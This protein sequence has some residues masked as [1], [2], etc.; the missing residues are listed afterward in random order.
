MT[1]AAQKSTKGHP[2]V[3]A[4]RADRIPLAISFAFI[5]S[6]LKRI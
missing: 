2:A 1:Q 6:D 4:T 5:E 3:M